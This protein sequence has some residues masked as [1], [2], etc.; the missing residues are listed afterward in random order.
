[1]LRY[2][3]L[4]NFVDFFFWLEIKN[5]PEKRRPLIDNFYRDKSGNGKGLEFRGLCLRTSG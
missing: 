1:M 4:D 3:Q 2:L 5:I